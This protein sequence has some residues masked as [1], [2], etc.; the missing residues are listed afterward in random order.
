APAI[1][2]IEN[3]GV[4]RG[5]IV[6]LAVFTT[7]DPTKE[8]MAVRDGVAATI[9]PPTAEDTEW[10]AA[11]VGPSWREYQGRY[12]PSPNYQ[13]GTIPFVHYGDGGE[14]EF[15]AKGMPIVQSKFDLRFSITV[16]KASICPMPPDGYPI[17]LYAH[18]TGGDWRSYIADGTAT[19]LAKHCLAA[20]GV[21]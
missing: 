17:V 1:D 9:E 11:P 2:E 4:P 6:H 20:M 5:T 10:V 13:R 15:D 3:V 16:P 19:A 12:G 7:S 18:G 8:L 21:D 14:F